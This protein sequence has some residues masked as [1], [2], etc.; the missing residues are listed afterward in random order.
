MENKEFLVGVATAYA[1]D[2]DDNLLF[3]GKTLLD[4]S[5]D[6]SLSN[7][8][9][10]GGEGNTLLYV[11]YHSAEMTVKL[12]ETQ[13]SLAYLALSV[14]DAIGTGGEIWTEE[15]VTLTNGAGT[16]TKTP[17]ALSTTTI[18]GWVTTADGTTTRVTFTGNQFTLPGVNG[19]VCVRYYTEN[20][21]SKVVTIYA[22]M[23]PSIVRLELVAT[24]A[25]SD[26]TTNKI[27]TIQVDIPRASMTGA[28][29]LN[30]TS[31]SV[32]N[33]PLNIRALAYNETS[34]GC[35][36]N[37]PMYAKITK[38]IY[39]TNWYDDVKALAI[40]GGDF[41]MKVADTKQLNVYAIPNSGSAFLAPIGDLTFAA[42]PSGI[43]T[44][45]ASGLVTGAAAG[46]SYV[47]ATIT[48]KPTVDA[49]QNA[50][51]TA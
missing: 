37:R 1:Y 29:T 30:M 27:G 25:S 7:T 20:P 33:T 48:A 15:S 40:E 11:Y 47:K 19:D 14:G 31:D 46:T 41:S 23:F 4:T 18:Y 24:L 22:N 34:G 42:D 51:V 35:N 49:S 38:T 50:T 26:A 43:V 12:T 10:R 16:V 36:G 5:I 21:S 9:V 3:T 32:A 45:S 6:V 39:N 17:L 2:N 13:F 28:F 44:V 8:D